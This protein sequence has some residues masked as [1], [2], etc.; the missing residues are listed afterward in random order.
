MAKWAK[1][2]ARRKSERE[3]AKAEG[4]SSAAKAKGSIP[5][6]RRERDRSSDPPETKLHKTAP[7]TLPSVGGVRYR[8]VGKT[9][10]T[11]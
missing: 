11:E 9:L 10:E 7:I 3:K 6:P 2:T 4:V 5:R 1:Q 8:Y